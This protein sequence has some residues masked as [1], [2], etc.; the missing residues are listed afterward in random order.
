MPA[1]DAL[2][3]SGDVYRFVSDGTLPATWR[4]RS[5]LALLL[6][7]L[8]LLGFGVIASVDA[9]ADSLPDYWGRV[10]L[11]G[12]A[13]GVMLVGVVVLGVALLVLARRGT[14]RRTMRRLFPAGSMTEVELKEDSLV[15]RRPTGAHVLPYRGMTRVQKNDLWVRV[16]MRGQARAELLPA[17]LLPEHALGLLRGRAGRTPAMVVVPD[18]E[19]T[20]SMLV[21]VGWA[22]HLAATHVRA[23]MGSAPLWVSTIGPASVG[24]LLGVLVAPAWWLLGPLV[25]LV[26]LLVALQRTRSVMARSVPAGSTATTYVLE[27]RFI[28]CNAGGTREI[29]FQD[30]RRSAV[31]DDVVVLRLGSARGHFLIARALLPSDT[32]AEIAH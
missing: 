24:G 22:D 8:F 26:R 5:R 15:I 27:D 31:Y 19:P 30:I 7:V 4:V 17:G 1:D 12:I 13:W 14:V 21:P 6:I 20:C 16:F 28:S 11:I 29:L 9:N 25:V 10:V 23:T 3:D 32:L 18:H 2:A